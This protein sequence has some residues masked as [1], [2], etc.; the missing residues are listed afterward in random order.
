MKTLLMGILVLIMGMNVKAEE[1]HD[2][3]EEK[4]AH[5]E[6]V[7]EGVQLSPQAEKNF[8][9]QRVAIRNNEQF[10]IA[11]STVVT[12]GT[13]KNLYRYRDGKYLRIDFEVL[14][15]VGE[16]LVVKSKDLKPGDEIVVSGMGLL[17][18]AEL[19]AT[20]GAPASH[21]H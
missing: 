15:K 10:E 20:G 7:F 3:G 2:H 17:R 21:S 9:I 4:Q 11:A 6:E 14:K 18:I 19:A 16:N 1:G 5:E 13:E 8:E 12:S